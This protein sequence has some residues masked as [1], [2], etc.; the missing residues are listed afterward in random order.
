MKKLGFWKEK[1][2]T[3][4]SKIDNIDEKRENKCVTRLWRLSQ[5]RLISLWD[6][7]WETGF[8]MSTKSYKN[9]GTSV[10]CF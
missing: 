5:S 3:E 8:S 1:S 7:K 2:S 4:T 10:F 9:L 6:K